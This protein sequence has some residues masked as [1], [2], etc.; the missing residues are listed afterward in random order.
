MKIPLTRLGRENARLRIELAAACADIERLAGR[1]RELSR[2]LTSAHDGQLADLDEAD[3]RAAR[4]RRLLKVGERLANAL[5][6]SNR[7]AD[8]LQSRLDDA[9]GLTSPAL[10]WRSTRTEQAKAEAL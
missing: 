7:R 6:T 10:N 4:I 3:R 8:L 5:K 1:N 9:V 2:R